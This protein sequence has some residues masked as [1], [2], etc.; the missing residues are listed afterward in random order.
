MTGRKGE[1]TNFSIVNTQI[2]RSMFSLA[3][4]ALRVRLIYSR[5]E[6]ERFFFGV[7]DQPQREK[8]EGTIM[9]AS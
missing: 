8:S 1:L 4:T 9:K 3:S 7:S 6:I 5:W 2:P